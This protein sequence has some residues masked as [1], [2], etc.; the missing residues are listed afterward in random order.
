MTSSRIDLILADLPYNIGTSDKLG[1]VNGVATTNKD[2]FGDWDD[3]PIENYDDMVIIFLNE[4]HRLL[5]DGG[6]LYF[7]TAIKDNGYFT[8]KATEIGFTYQNTLA[9]VKS[10]PIPSMGFRNY[11]SCFEL[12]AY[13]S[14]GKIKTFNFISQQYCKNVFETVN[15]TRITEH[16]TEKPLDLMIKMIRCSSNVGDLVLDPFAGSSTT[17]EACIKTGRNG[18]GIEKNKEYFEMS[19]R[20]LYQY[21]KL[22]NLDGERIEIEYKEE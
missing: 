8:R 13:L 2:A 15:N 3:K 17:L 14:K 18:I 22:V 9:L 16:P 20:R 11:R 19:K 4:S 21:D 6:G 7:F 10:N 12:C 5:K 1:M